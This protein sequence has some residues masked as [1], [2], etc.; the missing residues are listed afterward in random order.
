MKVWIIILSAVFFSRDVIGLGVPDTTFYRCGKEEIN[1]AMDK[2]DLKLFRTWGGDESEDDGQ[3]FRFPSDI[4][5]GPDNH[6]YIADSMQHRVQVFSREGR[7][8]RTIGQKGQGPGDLYTPQ[9]IAFTSDGRLV[10]AES[11]NKRIQVMDLKGKHLS[12]FKSPIAWISELHG[13]AGNL[14]AV[15]G[16]SWNP[17][18]PIVRLVNIQTNSITG[19]FGRILFESGTTR[20]FNNS[21]AALKESDQPE[22][23]LFT[24]GADGWYYIAAYATPFFRIY[25]PQKNLRRVVVYDTPIPSPVVFPN[26][27]GGEPVIKG[28]AQT[29]VCM[30]IAIDG[31]NCIFLAVAKRER[32]KEEVFFITDKRES[33]A[34]PIIRTDRYRLLVFAAE[35]HII[36]AKDLNVNCDRIRIVNKTLFVIDTYNGNAIYEYSITWK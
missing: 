27:C 8:I 26:P 11:G 34:P 5:V 17:E 25:D 23:Q 30:S 1:S 19:A 35:G 24:A 4:A 15:A 16:T 20:R 3:Y 33:K 32:K 14:L 6:I 31:G 13:L 22:T 7:F 21:K 12:M 28:K 2:I 36:A 29:A 9:M 10:I 18:A